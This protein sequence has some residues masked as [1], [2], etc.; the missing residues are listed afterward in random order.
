MP[1]QYQPT[2]E[3]R[4][5]QIFSECGGTDGNYLSTHYKR[6]A[7]TLECFASTWNGGARL[8]DVGGGWLHQGVLF[9]LAGFEVT[10]TDIGSMIWAPAQAAA[11]RFGIPYIGFESLAAPVE[12]EALPEASFDVILFA[13]IIE[14]ITFN[15]VRMWKALYRLLAPGGRIVVST[16]SVYSLQSSLWD[17]RRWI[18]RMGLGLPVDEI[19]MVKD[20]AHHW[21][22]YSVNELQR[23]FR[24]LSRDFR[25]AKALQVDGLYHE[26]WRG[27]TLRLAR[28]LKRAIPPL[29]QN[30][31]LEV[32]LPERREGIRIEPGWIWP[33]RDY[34]IP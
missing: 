8:L 15:P 1:W 5:Q 10:S 24:L 2:T 11:D 16:P 13:E 28:A 33:G 32:E 25:I 29:R 14:H 20:T 17:P 6:F 3:A 34:S 27:N 26:P 7:F 30:I 18:R 4:L 19:L 22:E 31:H 21:K 9:R 12:L 23:Y